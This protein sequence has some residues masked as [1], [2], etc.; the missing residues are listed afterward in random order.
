MRRS[1]RN[2][3]IPP[4]ATPQGIWTF[5]G[6]IVQIP[7]PRGKNAVQMPYQLVLKYLSSKTNFVFNQTLFT[8]FTER[9][10]VMTPSSF[11]EDP[12]EWVIH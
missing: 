8:L 10:V 2:F 1:I 9:Y 4:R 7:S 6:C 5:E 3:N 12:F 11:F